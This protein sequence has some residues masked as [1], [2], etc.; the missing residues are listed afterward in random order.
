VS[1]GWSPSPWGVGIFLGARHQANAAAIQTVASYVLVLV[2]GAYVVLTHRLVDAQRRQARDEIEVRASAELA[3]M[4]HNAKRFL[5]PSLEAQFPLDG[6]GPKPDF[7]RLARPDKALLD[8]YWDLNRLAPDLPR[9][10]GNIAD[11][12][13]R[14]VW[15]ASSDTVN[16]LWAFRREERAADIE[17]RSWTWEGAAR[18]YREEHERVDADWSAMRST[19]RSARFSPRL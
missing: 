15:M 13:W 3:R 1:R 5:I 14:A 4:L 18:F 9:G 8:L 12:T 11:E 7:E 16:I 2:T 6:R 19:L 17:T 10:L